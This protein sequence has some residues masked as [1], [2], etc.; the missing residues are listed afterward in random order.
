MP[1]ILSR[2][3]LEKSPKFTKTGWQDLSAR[4]LSKLQTGARIF[5]SSPATSYTHPKIFHRNPTPSQYI[6]DSLE[7]FHPAVY[8]GS[9]AGS[10]ESDSVTIFYMNIVSYS[11]SLPH[12]P[13]LNRPDVDTQKTIFVLMG[14]FLCPTCNQTMRSRLCRFPRT[15][16]RHTR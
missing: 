10:L 1:M 3:R 11:T 16:R 7:V 12:M 13:D 14:I 8:L 15:T 4:H 9:Q 6:L 2:Q 5:I